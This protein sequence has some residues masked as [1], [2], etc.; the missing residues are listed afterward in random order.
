MQKVFQRVI[1][2]TRVKEFFER[3]NIERDYQ[4]ELPSG[5]TVSVGKL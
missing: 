3:I 5:S 4:K 1:T 2:E